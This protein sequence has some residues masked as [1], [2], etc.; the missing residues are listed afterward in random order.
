[1]RMRLATLLLTALVTLPA[2]AQFE[3]L[4]WKA[5]PATGVELALKMDD[6]AL[7][8]DFDFKGHGGYAIARLEREL[9]LPENFEVS[10]RVRSA[11]APRNTLEVKLVDETGENV[12][13]STRPDWDWPREWRRVSIKRRHFRFAWGPKGPDAPLPPKVAALE[14]VVTA[15]TGG[16]GTVWL[17]DVRITALDVN[18]PGPLPALPPQATHDLGRRY[19]FGGLVIDWSAKPQRYEIATSLDGNAWDV[20]RRVEQTNGGRDWLWLPDTDAR[21][22]RVNTEGGTIG[23]MRLLPAEIS[24]SPNEFF[25]AMAKE[26]KRGDFPRYLYGEQSYW[27]V[28]GD[29]DGGE[30]EA[31]LSE[32]GAIELGGARISIEP[33]LRIDD[34][35][36]TWADVQAEQLPGPVVKWPKLTIRPRI[37]GG[38]LV[39]DYVVAPE[40]EL[41]LA[42]RPF[43]VNPPWQFLKR[44]GGT[45]RIPQIHH[46]GT[47]ITAEGDE[48]ATI[49]AAAGFGA[50]SFDNGDI[51]EYLRAGRLPMLHSVTDDFGYA[52][53]GL[54]FAR[55][56]TIR[57]PLKT[58]AARA[59][60]AAHRFTLDAPAEPR[61]AKSIEANLRYVLIN[62]DGAAIQ[63]GSRSYERS[64]IRDG[65]LTSA[66]LLRL[67]RYG[68]VR[69]FIE[70]Y[71]GYQYENGQIPC[72]VSAAGADPV[73]EHDS[74]GQFIYL[75]AE[76]YRHTRDRAFVQGLWPRIAKTVAAIDA[77]RHE[78][79]TAKYANTPFYGLVPESISHEGYS[80][81]P[82]H[83]YWDDFFILRGLE[84]AAFLANELAVPEIA[85]YATLRDEFRHDL[86]AS[87]RATIA[88]HGIDYIP[89]SVELGD[90]DA[91][92]TTV[93]IT[94]VDEADA[95]PRAELLRTF[96]KYWETALQT[97]DYTPYEL[98]VVGSLVRLG[99]RERAVT[100]LQRFFRDQRPP[101]WYQWAEVVHADPR[102]PAF[103]GDMPHTWVGSD[104]IRSALD[105]FVFERGNKLV[106]GAGIDPAWLDAGITIDG[107]STHYGVIGYTMKRE[108]GKV[109]VRL[110][111]ETDAEIEIAFP[112]AVL[113][114]ARTRLH[115]E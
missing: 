105:M 21:F 14:I 33:F 108:G 63:P 37:E 68:V 4:R 106:L 92:S 102:K 100:L 78:R 36:V 88:K 19:E 77:L 5:V 1:M 65:S 50:T 41:Y 109:V 54:S 51:V 30:F 10:F 98:R 71:A 24:T 2:A 31:L 49:F 86:H 35:F 47:L 15:G 75:V 79:M 11:E 55:N 17:D 9:A 85:R 42:I 25:A 110:L 12:W 40:A 64:W 84:D 6:G 44:T 112:G 45:V 48:L 81:K 62:R 61:L 76:Y 8:L 7:R 16:Q 93:A 104:F 43:Q 18:P 103:I 97:R 59:E 115:K 52:S 26:S 111:R 46:S 32:D 20:V 57:I 23:A 99:Q 113:V 58:K 29:E 56:A 70:W 67:G 94:P 60:P 83:S 101:A 90:F 3:E 34:Q 39:V 13:W 74:H 27:T 82:M 96:D 22:L 95:L 73:P 107:V 38:A 66:A 91:T 72:C 80:A 69:D 28:V 53:A 89:G 87:L 114:G